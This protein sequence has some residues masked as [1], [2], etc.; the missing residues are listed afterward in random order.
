[1]FMRGAVMG[2]T[3]AL[4]GAVFMAGAAAG[5]GVTLAAV[6]AACLA[7][8]AMKRRADWSPDHQDPAAAT[9]MPDEGEPHPGIPNPG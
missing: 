7:R 9:A 4:G 5:A 8:R 1:M 6:G 3:M 2:T